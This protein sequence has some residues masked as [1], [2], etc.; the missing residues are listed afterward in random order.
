PIPFYAEA[1]DQYFQ[2]DDLT[3]RIDVLT[4]ACKVVGAYDAA[5]ESLKR[6]FQEATEPNLIPVDSYA[7]FKEKGGVKG[8]IDLV[9]IS[10]I[11]NVL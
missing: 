11:A 5:T 6:I 7:V 10:T 9:D 8:A 4:S 3:R 1:Q 2:S